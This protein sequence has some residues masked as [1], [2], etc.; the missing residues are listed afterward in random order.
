MA[1]VATL[2][3]E[4]GSKRTRLRSAKY[5]VP[6]FWLACFERKD[7]VL[8]R[9]QDG[10]PEVTLQTTPARAL[11]LLSTRRASLETLVSNLDEFLPAWVGFLKEL[12]EGRIHV[13][14][15]E[16]LLM[17]EGDDLLAPLTAA[18]GFFDQI[19]EPAAIALIDL[20]SLSE[21]IDPQ[22][23]RVSTPPRKPA[24][25]AFPEQA[26]LFAPRAQLPEDPALEALMGHAVPPEPGARTSAQWSASKIL[27]A[28]AGVAATA[29]SASGYL[30]GR[31][32]TQ[33]ESL[34]L[35]VLL[36]ASVVL[37]KQPWRKAR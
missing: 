7:A 34:L 36:V 14:P 37:W 25:A 15:L 19:T 1:N 29:I 12:G 2:T 5:R 28:L 32:A 18:L 23:Q 6:L 21:H 13:D 20:A 31:R 3:F 26:E 27:A 22:T 17:S 35:V 16:V 9:D 33:L 10:E 24:A 8:G 11:E 30:T 4:S